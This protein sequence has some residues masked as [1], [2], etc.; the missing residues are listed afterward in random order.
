MSRCPQPRRTGLSDNLRRHRV[1]DREPLRRGE[2]RPDDGRTLLDEFHPHQPRRF[3][4]HH[5]F[6]S[7]RAAM[8]LAFPRQNEGGADIGVS[9]KRHLGARREDADLR[10]MRGILRRQHEGGLGEVELG[11]DRLH[12]PGRQP[13]G[14]DDHGER[15]A[16]EL[17]VGEYVDG[18]ECQ[19]HARSRREGSRGLP[20]SPAYLTLK[21]W[22]DLSDRPQNPGPWIDA[23]A[24]SQLSTA[25]GT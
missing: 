1:P 25:S 9:G 8:A 20:R 18:D 14:V 3:F 2:A 17:P 6:A 7:D 13:I 22:G 23:P 19:S 5:G 11:G 15:I 10:G 12:L 21:E 16:T 24:C 4:E